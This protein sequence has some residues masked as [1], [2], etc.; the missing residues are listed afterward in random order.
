MKICSKC[1]EPKNLDC[2][3]NCYK[4]KDGKQ[5]NCK[6][7]KRLY[8]QQHKN[9]IAQQQ[10]EYRR[11]NATQIAEKRKIYKAKKIEHI[12]EK[13]IEY[14]IK[15]QDKIKQQK[16][17]RRKNNPEREKEINRKSKVKHRDKIAARNK[18]Y[19]IDNKDK[20]KEYFQRPEVI[21][22]RK[23]NRLKNKEI[24]NSNKKYQEKLRRNTDSSYRL[25]TNQRTRITNILKKHKTNKTLNLIGCSAE[26]LRNYLENKFQEGMNWDNYGKYGWHVDHI[27]PCS[28][29]DLIDIEQ[30]KICFHYSNLQPLWAKDNL[31]K[32]NKIL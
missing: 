7:C 10:K 4:S 15:N 23:L 31:Q 18:Q 20:I 12:K 24:I 16:L 21:A 1:K 17:L 30:Q 3:G 28:S 29:F 5:W 25:I 22:R 32:S 9:H 11:S 27:I 2:F 8:K 13:G 6:D 19:R 26:F 14:R